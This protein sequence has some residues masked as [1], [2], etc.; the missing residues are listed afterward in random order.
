MP[1]AAVSGMTTG[2]TKLPA[3][4]LS[5]RSTPAFQVSRAS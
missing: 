3:C 1:P 5:N 4:V 2:N